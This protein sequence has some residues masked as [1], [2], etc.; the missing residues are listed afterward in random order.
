MYRAF[1]V[2]VAVAVA[3]GIASG[4][5]AKPCHAPRTGKSI[6]CP[7]ATVTPAKVE[8]TGNGMANAKSDAEADVRENGMPSVTGAPACK[9]G[10][11]CGTDCIA[12]DKV[13]HKP[14]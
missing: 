9:V 2:A 3:L 10:K 11:P 8:A 6:K 4:A 5:M 1:A 12:K 14:S 7:P 13:C